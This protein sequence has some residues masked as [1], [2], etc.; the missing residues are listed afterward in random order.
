M[1]HRH[2]ILVVED[3]LDQAESLAL[4]LKPEGWSVFT[5]PTALGGRVV[6]Q[7]HP[8]EIVLL[9]VVLPGGGAKEF[10]D[11]LGEKCPACQVYVMTG[12]PPDDVRWLRNYP[13]VE[14]LFKPYPP[15]AL[16]ALLRERLRSTKGG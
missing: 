12:L 4:I 14:V 7:V 15:D 11:W 3:C 9:D 16:I 10:L 2:N 1:P 8:P 13:T 6:A 5:A